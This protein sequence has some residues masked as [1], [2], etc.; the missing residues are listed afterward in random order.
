MKA[1]DH[2]L[3][4]EKNTLHENNSPCKENWTNFRNI[5]KKSKEKKKDV[6]NIILQKNFRPKHVKEILEIVNRIL[7]PSKK[8]QIS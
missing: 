4:T 5:R 3:I 8:I 6:K 1:L 7:N 2:N